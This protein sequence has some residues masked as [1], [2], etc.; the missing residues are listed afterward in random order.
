MMNPSSSGTKALAPQNIALYGA[1]GSGKSAVGKA[2][3]GQ[4]KRP[5]I[6]MDARIEETA[7]KT[8][9]EIFAEDGEPAFRR[10][11]SVLCRQLA[12]ESGWVIS[13][14]GGALVD[15]QNR[16]VMEASG[17]VIFLDC[18]QEVLL[19]RT[20]KADDRPLLSGDKEAQLLA[21]LE[22]RREVYGSFPNRVDA[23]ADNPKRIAKSVLALLDD[24]DISIFRVEAPLPAYEVVIGTNILDRVGTL[25]SARGLNPPFVV[26]SDSNVAP[27]YAHAVCQALDAEAVVIPAGEEYKTLESIRTFYDRFLEL[28]IERRATIVALGGGVI[29]DM[30]GFAAATFM[31]GVRWV[32]LPTTLLAM[33]DASIGG[34]VGVDLPQGKNLVGAFHQPALVI[35]D[36]ATLDTLPEREFRSGMAELFKGALIADPLL[37]EWIERGEGKAT[38]RWIERALVVKI[39]I[40]NVDPYENNVR[41]KLNLGHT[42]AHGLEAASGYALSHG[43]A[44]AIGLAAEARMA[45]AIGLAKNGLA[46]R[47]EAVLTRLGLPTRFQKLDIPTV[48]TAMSSDKK[49][50]GGQLR[51]ALPVEPGVAEIGQLIPE[52]IIEETLESV[53]ES[54]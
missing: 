15:P 16:A 47:I 8:I 29:G 34:K 21:L 9:P 43:E 5:F 26:V 7:G 42:V 39:D 24:L 40:V 38:K 2:V 37:F 41:A 28:G 20:Q 54:A 44:V 19:K 11:E 23:S 13:C 25:L 3:A 50:A 36:T 48:R 1:P 35:T 46:E 27:L 53:K 10:M 18:S 52:D 12:G 14:G 6:D 31:R 4:L 22:K 45:E 32:N 33:V 49:K 30:T 51:F 17:Q